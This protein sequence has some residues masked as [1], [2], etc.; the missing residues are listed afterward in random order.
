MAP[1]A[2]KVGPPSAPVANNR[3]KAPFGG[4]RRED[5][6]KNQLLPSGED[7]QFAR[8]FPILKLDF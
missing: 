6:N 7:Q 1:V 2:E 3:F 8:H 5:I 4:S